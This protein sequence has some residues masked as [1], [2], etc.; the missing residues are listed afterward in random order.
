MQYVVFR[1]VQITNSAQTLTLIV[2]P[3]ST[4]YSI[5]SGFQIAATSGTGTPPFVITQPGDETVSAGANASFG[6]LASGSGP[7]H[8]QWQFNGTN[9]LYG[10]N[11][12]LNFTNVGPANVGAYRVVVTNAFGVVISS[13]G[14]L[15]LAPSQS[16]I[17]AVSTT[18]VAGTVGPPGNLVAG[19]SEKRNGFTIKFYSSLL[20]FSHL[21]LGHGP[22]GGPLR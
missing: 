10:A 4:G 15:S 12:V 20:T 17:Q 11:S 22:S 18:A 16:V 1:G 6:L 7:L 19:G 3:G 8:Y 9:L 21:S 5:I 13:N 14:N 2:Y